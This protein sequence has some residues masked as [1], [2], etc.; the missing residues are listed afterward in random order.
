MKSFHAFT[1][2]FNNKVNVLMNEVSVSLAFNLQIS[3]FKKP[4]IK[5]YKAIWDTGATN[6]VVTEKVVKELGLKPISKTEVHGVG[7]PKIEN[8]HL[9]NLYLPNKMVV[10][11]VRVTECNNL[12]GGGDILIGMDIIGMGDFAVTNINERTIMSYRLP[13]V[14]E[15]DFVKVA[16]I[17]KGKLKKRILGKEKKLL[18]KKRKKERKNRKK[19]RRKK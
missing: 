14:K 12:S 11:Y 10:G 19:L 9:V 2:R 17:E 8:V 4:V 18:N 5:G 1:T 3:R 16:Q 6:S 7:D 15:I 13:S